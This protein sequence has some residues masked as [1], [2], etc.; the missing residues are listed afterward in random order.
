VHAV[1]SPGRIQWVGG[2]GFGGVSEVRT[3]TVVRVGGAEVDKTG[4]G[5]GSGFDAPAFGPAVSY[6]RSWGFCGLPR[7][8]SRRAPRRDATV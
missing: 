6:A 4:V 3:P 1:V 8:S 5:V 2:I 7:W